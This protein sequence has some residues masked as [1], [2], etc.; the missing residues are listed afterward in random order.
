LWSSVDHHFLKLRS[1][2]GCGLKQASE[3]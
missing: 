1:C 3:L 2:R